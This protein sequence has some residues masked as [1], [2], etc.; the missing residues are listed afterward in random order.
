M[1]FTPA[2]RTGTVKKDTL[3]KECNYT[4]RYPPGVIITTNLCLNFLAKH[5]NLSLT[6]LIYMPCTILIMELETA[7]N[8]QSSDI[9]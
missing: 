1:L 5:H 6:Q 3:R 2:R 7:S 9:C 4:K 8:T